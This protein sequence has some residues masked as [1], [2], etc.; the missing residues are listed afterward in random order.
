MRI[1]STHWLAHAVLSQFLSV[2]LPRLNTPPS[3][4]RPLL[5]QNAPSAQ[6]ADSSALGSHGVSA[7]SVLPSGN[8][9]LRTAVVRARRDARSTRA[10]VDRSAMVR[11]VEG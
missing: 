3:K 7:V 5:M 6:H 8:Q 2:Q 10:D 9:Q 4:H 1:L 11:E